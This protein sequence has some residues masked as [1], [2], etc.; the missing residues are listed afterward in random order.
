MK[1]KITISFLVI[2]CCFLLA[3]NKTV[4]AQQSPAAPAQAEQTKPPNAADA[5]P[6]DVSSLDTILKS[7]YEVISGDAGVKRDWNR[8]RSL[9]YAGARLIPSSKNREG[10]VTARVIT[11]EEFIER[12]AP[13]LE[14]E[15]FFEREIARRVENYGN[16]AHVFSTYD[17]KH[18]ASDEK[19]FARGINS[20]Q[21]F[22]D[23][24]RW[25]ILTIAWSPETPDTP[26]PK[27][28][29]KNDK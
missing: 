7:I 14:K 10:K 23:G 25:W 2:N 18:K 13:F 3:I 11:P 26:L 8:F 19:P 1:T 5:N 9:F 28:Y 4:H 22:N 21:L 15:G 12:S 16:I 27:K 24:K 20:I 29:L 17:S 6:A